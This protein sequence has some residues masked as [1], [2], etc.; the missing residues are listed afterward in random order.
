MPAA[1]VQP[2]TQDI[3]VF[4]ADV[5]RGQ[6]VCITDDRFSLGFSV[7]EHVSAGAGQH[8]VLAFFHAAVGATVADHDL[9][10]KRPR[11][12]R[13]AGAGIVITTRL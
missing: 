10:V 12:K 13:I 1:A 5:G 9:A 6:A 7:G 8:Q 2:F 11:I 3:T 4:L